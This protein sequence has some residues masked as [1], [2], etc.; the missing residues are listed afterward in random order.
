L[1]KPRE[2]N[3]H[4]ADSE[5][6]KEASGEIEEIVSHAMHPLGHKEFIGSEA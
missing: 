6:L 2:T 5:H 3:H 4:K 1:A